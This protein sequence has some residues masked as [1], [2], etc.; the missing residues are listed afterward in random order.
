MQSARGLPPEQVAE[1][2]REARALLPPGSRKH[3][4]GMLHSIS[5]WTREAAS[6]FAAAEAS[7]DRIVAEARESYHVTL[8]VG[9]LSHRGLTSVTRGRLDEAQELFEEALHAVRAIDAAARRP[10]PD[11]RPGDAN[12]LVSKARLGRYSQTRSLSSFERATVPGPPHPVPCAPR[13]G[14]PAPRG[15]RGARGV[16]LELARHRR[17][18]RS[19]RRCASA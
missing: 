4:G 2:A 19:V 8:L 7:S 12:H 18:G 10:Q 6:D 11:A 9:T 15:G 5:A 3:L 16:A 14:G 1:M 17:P 13:I